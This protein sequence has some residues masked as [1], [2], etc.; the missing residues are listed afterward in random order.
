MYDKY[1][2]CAATNLNTSKPPGGS[3][4]H[5]TV[6]LGKGGEVFCILLAQLGLDVVPQDSEPLAA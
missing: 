1:V 4:C 6:S 3:L 5:L 2:M